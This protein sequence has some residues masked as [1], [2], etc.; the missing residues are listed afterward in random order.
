MLTTQHQKLKEKTIGATKRPHKNT[1][2]NKT[3][4][5]SLKQTEMK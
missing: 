2:K 3:F 4:K 5:T 1:K